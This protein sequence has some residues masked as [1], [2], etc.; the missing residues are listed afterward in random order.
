MLSFITYLDTDRRAFFGASLVALVSSMLAKE[1]GVTLPLILLLC[2]FL[3]YERRLNVRRLVMCV[4]IAV[5]LVAYLL[6]RLTYAQGSYPTVQRYYALG[7]HVPGNLWGYIA[8]LAF[9]LPYHTADRVTQ[10]APWFGTLRRIAAV[11]ILSAL[12][13]L[14]YVDRAPDR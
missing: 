10:S 8:S 3:L 1:E 5:V 4:P 2:E 6:I 12:C 7:W 13:G 11:G 9:P 14:A